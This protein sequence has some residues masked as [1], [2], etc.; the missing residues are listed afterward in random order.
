MSWYELYYHFVWSTKYRAP[1]IDGA[2]EAELYKVIVAKCK[3]LDSWVYA[4]GGVQDHV[5]LIASV[6]PTIPIATFTN[7]VKGNSSHFVNH[8]IQPTN[9]FAWQPDYSVLSF[10]RKHLSIMVQYVRNQKEHHS[11]GNLYKGLEPNDPPPT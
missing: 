9:T 11:S 8:V 4:I 1:T 7:Q 2:W 10:H 5:H 3:A 6:S